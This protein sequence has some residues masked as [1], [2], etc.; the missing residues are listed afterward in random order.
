MGNF[1][2][3]Y[4]VNAYLIFKYLRDLAELGRWNAFESNLDD[5]PFF[6]KHMDDKGDHILVDGEYNITG[7]IDWTY[8]R[9]V[10]AYEAFGPSLLTADTKDL[11]NGK[12]GRS[13]Q[14]TVM[15]EVLQRRDNCLG[16]IA[17][18]PDIVRRFS[19]FLGMGMD[20][21]WKEAN[22]LFQGIISTATGIPLDLDWEV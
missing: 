2:S 4:P 17:H 10:P 3:A 13:F 20:L 14:D 18:G 15:A 12:A 1:F 9:V 16:R 21:S 11:F 8:A 19:F 22:A 5:G 7:I 6:L